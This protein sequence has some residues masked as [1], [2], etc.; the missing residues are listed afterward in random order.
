MLLLLTAHLTTARTD[1]TVC[2]LTYCRL[3]YD[4]MNTPTPGH[5]SHASTA[6][7]SATAA[8][9]NHV[10]DI[11]GSKS[12]LELYPAVLALNR[13][14]YTVPYRR[15]KNTINNNSVLIYF[16]ASLT[17]QSPIT[18]RAQNK[19]VKNY[20]NNSKPTQTTQQHNQ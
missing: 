20:T 13:R 15:V 6:A 4:Y 1:C 18:K 14:Q 3:C 9:R 10:C 19:Y 7:L 12:P 17:E 2:Y 16:S 11:S 5:I 8:I